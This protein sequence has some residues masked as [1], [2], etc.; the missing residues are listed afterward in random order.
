M[1]RP[2]FLPLAAMVAGIALVVGGIVM[3]VIWR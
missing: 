1:K 2:A 3:L